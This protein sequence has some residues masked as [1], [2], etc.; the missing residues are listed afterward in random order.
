MA[1]DVSE[2]SPVLRGL[3]KRVSVSFFSLLSLS[4]HNLNKCLDLICRMLIF[5]QPCMDLDI[6][7]VYSIKTTRAH[8]SAEAASF[9]EPHVGLCIPISQV[10]EG[11]TERESHSLNGVAQWVGSHPANQKVTS[12]IPGEGTCLGCWPGPQLGVQE[13]TDPCFS[14]TWMF[15]L[16]PFSLPSLLSKNKQIKS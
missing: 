15:L 11:M 16:L 8:F 6:T 2:S 9:S 13:A 12:W 5:S 1:A 10:G 14:C 3:Q 7:G 4:L